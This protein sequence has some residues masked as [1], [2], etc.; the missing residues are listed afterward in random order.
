[1]IMYDKYC[2]RFIIFYVLGPVMCKFLATRKVF[3]YLI[4]YTVSYREI[5]AVYR[6]LPYQFSQNAIR[7]AKH[8]APNV[9]RA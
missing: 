3:A 7:V 2:I 6:F 8:E 5:S 9:N 1:M 4:L